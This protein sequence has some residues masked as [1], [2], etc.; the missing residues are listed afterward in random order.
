MQK[1]TSTTATEAALVDL[2][3]ATAADGSNVLVKRT[4]RRL[5]TEVRAQQRADRETFTG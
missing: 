2:R 4:L 1:G 3:A 5:T